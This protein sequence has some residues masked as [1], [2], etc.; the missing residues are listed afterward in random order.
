[1]LRYWQSKSVNKLNVQKKKCHIVKKYFDLIVHSL[2]QILIDLNYSNSRARRSIQLNRMFRIKKFRLRLENLTRWSS[3]Y[4]LLESV[5]RAFDAGL[6]DEFETERNSIQLLWNLSSSSKACLLIF[7]HFQGI[8]ANI[9]KIIPSVLK[10][11]QDNNNKTMKLKGEPKKLAKLITD[12]F[13][14]ILTGK[15]PA[16]MQK[17]LLSFNGFFSGFS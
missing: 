11:I 9:Y 16:K 6:F 3:A 12:I 14:C 13:F 4:L 1:M 8:N 7:N 5:K 15:L 2:A 17:K 10:L